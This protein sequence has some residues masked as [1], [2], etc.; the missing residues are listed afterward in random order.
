MRSRATVWVW[1]GC[2]ACVLAVHFQYVFP[3]YLLNYQGCQRRFAKWQESG[4]DVMMTAVKADER[5]ATQT[6]PTLAL[7]L[8]LAARD[9]SL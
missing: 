6:L 1:R 5:K 2:R 7:A 9:D 4:R 3:E 8:A